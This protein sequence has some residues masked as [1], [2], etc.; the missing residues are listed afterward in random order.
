[1][2]GSV[3]QQRKAESIETRLS[4][5]TGLYVIVHDAKLNWLYI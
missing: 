4:L 5:L 2:L 3:R 1:M